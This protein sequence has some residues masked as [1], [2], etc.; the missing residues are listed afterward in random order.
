MPVVHQGVRP[1][2]VVE[3]VAGAVAGAPDDE[4]GGTRPLGDAIRNVWGPYPQALGELDGDGGVAPVADPFYD[5]V[6]FEIEHRGL[7][8]TYSSPWST[9]M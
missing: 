5:P 6:Q 7:H 9:S 3:K 8:L 2:P 1:A 4:D